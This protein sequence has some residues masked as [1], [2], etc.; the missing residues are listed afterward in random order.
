MTKVFAKKYWDFDPSLC[1]AIPLR[2]EKTRERLIKESRPGDLFLFVATKTKD[3]TPADKRGRML[4]I[5]E[6]DRIPVSA[7]GLIAPGKRKNPRDYDKSGNYK[8]PYGVPIVRAWEFTPPPDASKFLEKNLSRHTYRYIE[9]LDEEDVKRVLA[10]DREEIDISGARERLQQAGIQKAFLP[11]R[12]TRGPSPSSG[13]IGYTREN[14]GPAETYAMRFGQR[15]IWK[16]GY[17]G[18]IGRRFKEVNGH[19]PHEVLGEY[20]EFFLT[21]KWRSSTAAHKMEQ[22]VLDLL[23]DKRTDRERV[24]CTKGELLQAWKKAARS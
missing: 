18:N 24:K 3:V 6:F 16:I 1:P 8:W 21:K 20:W 2:D 23:E 19:I 10:L 13:L 11:S 5:V 12:P 22:R 14:E 17:S 9:E 4:G 15:N 7:E